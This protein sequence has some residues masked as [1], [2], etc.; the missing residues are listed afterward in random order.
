MGVAAILIMWPRCGELIFVPPAHEESK[1]NLALIGPVVSEEK[2]FGE[3]GRRTDVRR[4]Y[5]RTEEPAYTIGLLRWAKHS[6][7]PTQR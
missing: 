6:D 7:G 1:W 4:A 2:T 5:G 3:C